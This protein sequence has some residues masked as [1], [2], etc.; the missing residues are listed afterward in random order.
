MFQS[1]VDISLECSLTSHRL[2]QT[3][4]QLNHDSI[5]RC[6]PTCQIHTHTHTHSHHASSSSTIRAYQSAG[7]SHHSHGGLGGLGHVQQVVEQCLVL[8][9]GEQVELI[10]DEQHRTAAAAVPWCEEVERGGINGGMVTA[11]NQQQKENLLQPIALCPS[12]KRGD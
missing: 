9:V 10:Q 2:R 1:L 12:L 3:T 7:E 6:R 8:V 5:F 11:G 4:V